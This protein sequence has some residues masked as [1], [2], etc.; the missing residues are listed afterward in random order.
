MSDI[1]VNAY[2]VTLL[3]HLKNCEI[4][5]RVINKQRSWNFMKPKE[6][7]CS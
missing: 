3:I 1:R 2:F 5:G 7:V 4:S 6:P